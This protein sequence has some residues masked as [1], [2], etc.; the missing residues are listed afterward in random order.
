[1]SNYYDLQVSAVKPE[2]ANAVTIT[3]AIPEKLQE[4]FKVIPGQHVKL[5]ATIEGE[6][7][8]RFYSICDHG[9]DF[10]Q[11]GIKRVAGGVF[12]N[13][14]CD[15]V[16]S[17]DV[18]GVQAPQGDFCLPSDEQIEREHRFFFLAAGSGITPNY[19]MLKYVLN[20]FDHTEVVLIY[21][22]P[23]RADI[24]FFTELDNL[25][26]KYINR[27]SVIHVVTREIRD[28]PMLAQRPDKDTVGPLIDGFVGTNI[29]HVY[30]CGPLP[31]I[32]LFRETFIDKGLDKK[33]IHLELFGTPTEARA[34][35]KVDASETDIMITIISKGVTQEIPIAEDQ[36]VLDAAIAAGAD[37]P[38]A[39]KGGV[40]ATCKAKKL[41]GEADMVLNYGLEDDDVARGMML[42][43]QTFVKSKKATFDFDVQ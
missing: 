25:K 10:V 32:E 43:C 13:Y 31:L 28:L 5:K 9:K 35:R 40:C 17:G 37:V 19:A 33:R 18:L 24:M 27:F 42:T 7:V 11:V 16:K 26:N 14:A 41:D 23:R 8:E 4:E 22:N 39:C 30:M 6:E 2:T 1:M 34:P 3:F 38:F 29:D 20:N 12:S 21:V 36:D 15:H